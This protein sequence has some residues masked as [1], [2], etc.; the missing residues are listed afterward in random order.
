MLKACWIVTLLAAAAGGLLVLDLFMRQGAS[1]PQ[2]AAGAAIACALCIVP[3]VFTRAVEGLKH[4][5]A[6]QTREH[7]SPA[8]LL[9]RGR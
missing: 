3:Y 8:E 4:A 9:D 2:E 6:P 1:A 5:P 7:I